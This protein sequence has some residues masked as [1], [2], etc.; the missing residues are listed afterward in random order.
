MPETNEMK[1]LEPGQSR[2]V[3]LTKSTPRPDL[4]FYKAFA[5]TF[6]RLNGTEYNGT[7]LVR[8]LT[9][10][11]RSRIGMRIAV[12]E[13]GMPNVDPEI[14]RINDMVATLD[15]ALVQRPEDFKPAEMYDLDVLEAVYA[16]VAAFEATFRRPV[17]G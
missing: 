8:R 14:H 5:L 1:P 13:G 9:I 15:A 6:C 17:E 11:D 4:K 7:F 2:M 10:G 12:L 16:E 3:D